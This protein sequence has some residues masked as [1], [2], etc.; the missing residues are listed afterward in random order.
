MYPR[1]PRPRAGAIVAAAMRLVVIV[2]RDP[3]G[4][5]AA[6]FFQ[7]AFDGRVWKL[8]PSATL[9]VAPVGI[10]RRT[11]NEVGDYAK[12]RFR[13][14]VNISRAIRRQW[15]GV[16]VCNGLFCCQAASHEE[17][18]ALPRW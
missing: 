2:L 15:I 11:L 8:L 12:S 6:R 18:F 9:I 10:I 17:L 5:T 13:G 1:K 7:A 14:L 3:A 4:D 16:V